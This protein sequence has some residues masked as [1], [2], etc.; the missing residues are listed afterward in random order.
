M[1]KLTLIEQINLP[2]DFGNF[3]L[4]CFKFGN[5][6]H[7]A[8]TK[9]ELKGTESV[10]T[11]V[12]SSCITGETFNAK[13]CDCGEQLKQAMQMIEKEGVGMIIYLFQE[14]RGLGLENKMRIHK[15][16]ETL[17]LN[18]VEATHQLGLPVDARTYE[19]TKELID[20]FGINSIRLLTN[21][22]DKV[23]QI[24]ELGSIIKEVI[25]IQIEPNPHNYNY[26]KTKRDLLN[27]KLNL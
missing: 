25:P 26:L 24:Q 4:S 9:G 17:G 7:L 14:G 8:L 18:T 13:L 3:Q 23:K 10:L 19:I 1:G 11:R 2:T 21:N 27:H 16:E 12:H 22:P 15:L 6:S 5:D 20:Y